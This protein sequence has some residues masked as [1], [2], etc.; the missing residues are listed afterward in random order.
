[1]NIPDMKNKS[2]TVYKASAGSGK[3]FTLTAEYIKM[4]MYNPANFHSILAV[5]FTNKATEE[6][7]GRILS[8]LYGLWKRLPDS[9]SYLDKIC[10]EMDMSEEMVSKQA[11]TALTLLVHNYNYFRIQTIDAFFQTVLRN[12][13]RELD[14]AANLR[15]ELNDVQIEQQVVDKMINDLKANDELLAWIM[16]FIKEKVDDD[17]S[18][19]VIGAIKDFGKNIFRTYFKENKKALSETIATPDFFNS[20]TK[21]LK[22]ISEK[23]KKSMALMADDFFDLLQKNGIDAEEFSNWKNGACGYF[24]RLKDGIIPTKD[25]TATHKKAMEDAEAWV[26]K[27]MKDKSRRQYLIDVVSEQLLPFF[28]KAEK[29]REIAWSMHQSAE[30][31]LK[32]LHELRLLCYISEMVKEDNVEQNRF[33]LSDTQYLLHTLIKDTDTP[34]IYEKIG[35][36]INHIM[37]DEFQDTGSVQWSNFKVLLDDCM[38][39]NVDGG[40]MIVGDVKQS[41]YRWRDGD[42]RLLNN[43]DKEFSR[44]EERLEITHLTTNYRSE[45][46]VVEFN[47]MFFNAAASVECNKM[48]AQTPDKA[49]VMK[50]AYSDVAQQVPAGKA[51]RGLVEVKILPD[52]KGENMSEKMIDYVCKT[53]KSLLAKGIKAKDIAVLSR[54]TKDIQ[55]I[56]DALSVQMPDITVISNEAYRLDNSIAVNAIVWTMALLLHPDDNIMQANLAS[57]CRKYIKGTQEDN[58][59]FSKKE[60]IDEFVA[61]LLNKRE[62]LMTKSLIDLASAVQE[63]LQLD[64]IPGQSAYLCAFYDQLS[65]YAADNP[66]DLGNFLE[67]WD[68]ALCSKTIQVDDA[69]GIRLITIHK[70]KG[71]E[72]NNVII[73]FCDWKLTNNDY[74][75][76]TP[77]DEP[78]NQLALAPVS[79]SYNTMR[80]TGF[81]NDCLE[82]SFQNTID[83][84]N[85][86]YVAFTRASHNLFV[87]GRR[88]N[89]IFR[90]NVVE[91]T[92]CKIAEQMPDAEFTKGD[93][94]NETVFKYGDLYCKEEKQKEDVSKNV[95]K[96]QV[97]NIDI[98]FVAH[99]SNVE[100]KQSNSS[101]EFIESDED[102]QQTSFIKKGTVLHNLFS[103]I[104]TLDDV[105]KIVKTYDEQGMLADIGVTY[106]EFT[107]AI[108]NRLK[109][110]PTVSKWFD[111][112]WEIFNECTILSHNPDTGKAEE[113]RPDRVMKRGDNVVVVDFKFGKPHDE[114][115]EQVAQYIS[116]I[117]AMGLSNVTGYLWYFYSNTIVKVD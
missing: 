66:A 46:N 13:A 98:D 111:E 34:F 81:E 80:G 116:L 56:A 55:N 62:Q 88:A 19:N 99:R 31:I 95:F 21:K 58:T 107:K 6:M 47:N 74:L 17:K 32:H 27:T 73:P 5:T 75:W 108:A 16:A 59:P 4:L 106:D 70:S 89:T 45:R 54:K 92:L 38:S 7:K 114:H 50:S 20:Y 29:Q 78:F 11:G 76:C 103:N 22:E 86:L 91:E 3:T 44:A 117:K 79:N 33:L 41:I 64:K 23:S 104:R 72:F 71:L 77:K 57:F 65:Q 52:I 61:P 36:Q 15:I 43:I 1:M 113:H 109:Q 37:I 63:L 39:R 93:K 94:D 18:W 14:L 101:R 105:E 53:I 10:S 97:E 35:T 84:L 26:R 90:S 28:N 83:N 110:Q 68:E 12:L 102:E 51:K 87:A 85:L 8:Q 25:I 2:L 67:L 69:D 24:L 9:K 60:E 30:Q 42:W 40:N 49:E 115:K 48:K 112:S 82:E 100:F 96:P